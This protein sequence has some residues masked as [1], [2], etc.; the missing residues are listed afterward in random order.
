M[1]ILLQDGI[2]FYSLFNV[3]YVWFL[4]Y[5]GKIFQQE[6]YDCIINVKYYVINIYKVYRKGVVFVVWGQ[7]SFQ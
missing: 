4:Q 5:D 7:G 1:G 3:C 2:I 6:F